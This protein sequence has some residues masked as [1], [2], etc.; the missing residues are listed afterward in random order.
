MFQLRQIELIGVD[1]GTFAVKI[2]QLHRDNGD[3]TVTAA[4]M[5]EIPRTAAGRQARQQ[6]NVARALKSCLRKTGV[7]TR[8]AVCGVSGQEVA[9]RSFAGFPSLPQQEM[10]NAVLLEASQI[11]PFDIDDGAVSYQVISNVND[12]ITGVLVAATNSLI[13]KKRNCA[14]NASLDTVLM[15]VDGLALLNCFTEIEKSERGKTV[16]ILN[17]G[18]SYANLAIMGKDSLPFV[19]DV[20][21][22]GS[23]VSELITAEQESSTPA[24]TDPASKD[25]N[26]TTQWPKRS[27][28][29]QSAFQSLIV[30]V[31]ETLRY[32]AAQKKT[33]F[34][35]KI[36]VCGGLALFDG[37]A[38]WLGE[39]LVT[40]TALWN[41]FKGMP[42]H[43]ERSCR[44]MLRQKGPAMAVA[45]GFAM[46]SI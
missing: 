32:Y 43:A 5:V 19:R 1:I 26:P 24:T 4:G 39:Q 2:V 3:W 18:N 6:V 45:A 15:D 23:Q 31:N 8:F 40:K 44:D 20:A 9:V 28:A 21:C 27:P 14:G 34:V 11:C 37:F 35:E 16:A 12:D 30:D 29:I 25:Q 38:E 33:A 36:L 42:C 7:R 22:P 46:R 41:P 17:V 10:R 13:E